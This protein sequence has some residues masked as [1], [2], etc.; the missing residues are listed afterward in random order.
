MRDSRGTH[1][2]DPA[3]CRS[4]CG[5]SHSTERRP[6]S[7]YAGIVWAPHT[8]SRHAHTL[9]QRVSAVGA[10]N[11]RA[12]VRLRCRHV[13][14]PRG[15]PHEPSSGHVSNKLYSVIHHT[16]SRASDSECMVRACGARA[17]RAGS[18]CALWRRTRCAM[19]SRCS[20]L[21]AA[22]TP[23]SR[24]SLPERAEQ[25]TSARDTSTR[26]QTSSRRVDRPQRAARCCVRTSRG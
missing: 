6:T 8:L 4:V 24:P 23:S 13:D 9:R 2:R 5:A 16:W 10:E 1:A 15:V 3:P 21:S 17:T 22:G 14:V 26:R 20:S 11:P 18:T 12:P 7:V 19:R 25:P